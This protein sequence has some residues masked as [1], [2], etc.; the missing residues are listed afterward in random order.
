MT[1]IKIRMIKILKLLLFQLILYKLTTSAKIRYI[2]LSNASE[3]IEILLNQSYLEIGF[4]NCTYN[5]FYYPSVNISFEHLNSYFI[6]KEKEY[7]HKNN[8]IIYKEVNV[9]FYLNFIFQFPNNIQI[10]QRLFCLF[11][12]EVIRFNQNNDNTFSYDHKL[13]NVDINYFNM[14]EYSIISEIIEECGDQIKTFFQYSIDSIF[15][16]LFKIYPKSDNEIIIDKMI[17]Y[18]KQMPLT[19][20][21]DDNKNTYKGRIISCFY[22]S[23]DRINNDNGVFN[24]VNLELE[25]G[26]NNTMKYY[27]INIKYIELK[28]DKFSFCEFKVDA[29][30]EPIKNLINNIF[31]KAYINIID[32]WINN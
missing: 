11:F 16:K 25:F 12:F 13:K 17:N 23:Y 2:P 22:D 32:I 27:K 9:D 30:Y 19:L 15:Y 14:R 8:V 31:H 28:S 10:N 5:Q 3:T 24:S 29:Y 18:F 6:P 1:E 21:I 4:L 20:Y 7:D 26:Y